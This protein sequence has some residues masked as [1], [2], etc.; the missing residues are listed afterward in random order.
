MAADILQDLL[1]GLGVA[2]RDCR[3]LEEVEGEVTLSSPVA[4][5]AVAVFLEQRPNIPLV[6]KVA[7][8]SSGLSP[9]RLGLG[10]SRRHGGLGTSQEQQAGNQGRSGPHT[11]KL[12]APGIIFREKFAKLWNG[13]RLCHPRPAAARCKLPT[14]SNFPRAAAGLR[15]SR[16]PPP[17]FLY[18]VGSLLFKLRHRFYGDNQL[19]QTDCPSHRQPLVPARH[20]FDEEGVVAPTQ[21]RRGEGG[22]L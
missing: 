20:A 9:G 11:R 8:G 17:T 5:T 1:P 3:R 6:G 7:L 22:R 14:P 4:V 10:E 16:A 15:H 2:D 19:R 18:V 13:A 12:D 21:N